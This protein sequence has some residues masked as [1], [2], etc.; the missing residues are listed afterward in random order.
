MSGLPEPK[1]R[2][3]VPV[4]SDTAGTKKKIVFQISSKYS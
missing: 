2:N 4:V 3:N 1:T